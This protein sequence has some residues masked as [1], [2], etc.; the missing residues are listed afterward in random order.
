MTGNYHISNM[1]AT[2][3]GVA[4]RNQPKTG[5]HPKLVW[6]LFWNEPLGQATQAS[7]LPASTFKGARKRLED[8]GFIEK[9]ENGNWCAT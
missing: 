4:R 9:I 7:G 8:E 5:L 2:C 1:I 6:L 3:L